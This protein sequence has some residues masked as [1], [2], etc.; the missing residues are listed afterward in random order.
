MVRRWLHLHTIT[1]TATT[2]SSAIPLAGHQ[3]Q[4]FGVAQERG[5][6][7]CISVFQRTRGGVLVAGGKKYGSFPSAADF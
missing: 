7:L 4:W 6:R 1:A 3:R 5:A 2:T